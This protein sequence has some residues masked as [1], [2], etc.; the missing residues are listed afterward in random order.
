M[1]IKNANQCIGS[2]FEWLHSADKADQ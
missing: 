1:S 2:Q